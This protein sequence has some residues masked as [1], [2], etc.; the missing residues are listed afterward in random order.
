MTSDAFGSMLLREIDENADRPLAT[1]SREKILEIF[2][3]IDTTDL[4]QLD[5]DKLVEVVRDG[6]RGLFGD[7]K[8]SIIRRRLR[9]S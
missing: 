7:L 6:R 5:W 8:E 1:A 9:S 2:H 3:D 4:K